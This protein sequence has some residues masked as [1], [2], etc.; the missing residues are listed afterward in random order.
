MNYL[1]R[2]T[3]H[4]AVGILA[5]L[6]LQALPLRAQQLEWARQF[7]GENSA[8]GFSVAVDA[9]GNVYTT[10]AFRETVDFDP[11]PGV[12]DMTAIG[13]GSNIFVTKLDS[14]GKLVWA[15][16]FGGGGSGGGRSVAV[17]A[18]GNVYTTGIFGG[19]ADFDPG[20]GFFNLT[21]SGQTA[22]FVTKLDSA[23]RF[24][25]AKTMGGGDPSWGA[26]VAVDVS[27]NVYL[28]GFFRSNRDFDPGPEVLLLASAGSE[29][30]GI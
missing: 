11:G 20:A 24:V 21:A 2:T 22:P 8:V 18:A 12:F 23:G 5:S 13:F 25:W 3:L 30:W 9:S 7:G 6:L 26:S 27:G 29:E 10:G 16:Q 4:L 17:D 15:R 1:N 19:T 28:T 14:A